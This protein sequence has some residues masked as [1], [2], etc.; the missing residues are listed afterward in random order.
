MGMIGVTFGDKHSFDDWHVYLDGFEV[1]YPTPRRI[2]VDVPL[3]NGVLDV[4]SALTGDRIYYENRKIKIDFKVI[5][6]PLPWQELY[7]KIANYL[8]G[9]PMR[10]I[11]DMDPYYYWD[12]YS[13]ILSTPSA[14][15]DV[16]SFSIE[17]DCYPYKKEV[18]EKTTGMTM[19][20]VS[21]G[22]S[23]SLTI[24]NNGDD[25]VPTIWVSVPMT[26]KFRNKTYSLPQ[27]YTTLQSVRMLSGD[28]KF[29][30]TKPNDGTSASTVSVQIIYRLGEL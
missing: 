1:E 15:E 11:Y 23:Q 30:F 7:S 20:N 16:G 3:R 24:K 18:L 5:D 8:H 10:I 26:M 22:S 29:L 27:G 25:V 21:P 12:A 9:K 19:T 2:T 28:N 13:C 14:D 4:T 6:N 17:C